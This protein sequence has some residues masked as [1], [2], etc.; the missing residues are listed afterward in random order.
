MIAVGHTLFWSSEL[1]GRVIIV[2]EINIYDV[3]TYP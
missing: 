2:R 3:D 1:Y